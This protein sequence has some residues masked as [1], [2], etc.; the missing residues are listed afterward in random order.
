M[1]LYYYDDKWENLYNYSSYPGV[2]Y[3]GQVG[4]T[5]NYPYSLDTVSLEKVE[6]VE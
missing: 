5:D 6:C 2:A 3:I 4:D 1:L